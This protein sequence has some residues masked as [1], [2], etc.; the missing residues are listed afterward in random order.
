MAA[1]GVDVNV[2][3]WAAGRADEKEK[4]GDESRES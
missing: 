3:T 1:L 4:T 2:E